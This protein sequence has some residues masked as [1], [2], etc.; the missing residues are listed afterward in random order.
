MAKTLKELL[1]SFD[2]NRA[3]LAKQRLANLRRSGRKIGG[4]RVANLMRMAGLREEELDDEDLDQLDEVLA[5]DASA[6][7][8][9]HDFV[10]SSNPKFEGKSKKDRIKMA[11]GAYYHTKHKKDGA[12][13]VEEVELDEGLV[14]KV[15]ASA[16]LAAAAAS[17]HAHAQDK[18]SAH[19]ESNPHLIAH[20][21]HGEKVHRFDLGKMFKTHNDA[22]EH[23]SDA[24]KRHGMTNHIMHITNKHQEDKLPTY[25]AK[26][27]D[28]MDKT[29]AVQKV[30]SGNYSD[31]SP[32][33]KH[34]SDKK[35]MTTEELKGNQH[36]LDKNKN[37]KIDKLDFKLLRKK[38]LQ[39]TNQNLKEKTELEE[40]TYKHE[41]E[42]AFP[43][44]GVKTGASAPK[45]TSTMPKDKNKAKGKPAG[46]LPMSKAAGIL[47]A[48]EVEKLDER[49]KANATMRK[50]MDASRGARYK[51]SGNP[52][53]DPDPKKHSSTNAYNKSI[54]RALRNMEE[55][56]QYAG[57]E[58][59]DKPGKFTA[60]A[61]SKHPKGV[62]IDTVEGWK[63]IKKPVKEETEM[64]KQISFTE[65][66]QLNEMEFVNGRYVHKG[67]YGTAKGAKYGN[68]DYERDTIDTKDDDGESDAQKRGRGRPA[69]AK[70]GARKITGTS[71]LYK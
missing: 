35:Y 36:K 23:M 45:G 8:W 69:G 37:G 54:G 4:A 2:F 29:P 19:H 32:A 53:P 42:K 5:A 71:K 66:L 62:N 12:G 31:N 7:D 43:A 22:R 17:P 3:A 70:S 64:E 52:V 28:Y 46:A 44:S 48:E 38:Q 50:N 30:T 41:V 24:L 65:F 16:A 58:K 25:A 60:G 55:E 49:N 33:V 47:A 10:H 26:H 39:R 27:K 6:S 68:T 57:L 13:V 14:K 63:D 40:G 59:E 21:E 67:T 11:L 56:S 51:Y 61:K 34:H 20:V 15:V 1:E 18:E 9:I